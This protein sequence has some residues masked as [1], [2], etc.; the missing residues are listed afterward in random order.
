MARATFG[1][2][3]L[4]KVGPPSTR[5]FVL[6]DVFIFKFP[7]QLSLSTHFAPELGLHTLTLLP[8]YPHVH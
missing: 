2:V 7:G 6:C 1:H 8:G 3:Q 4:N 5:Y